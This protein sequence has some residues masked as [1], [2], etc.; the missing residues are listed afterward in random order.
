VAADVAYNS[1]TITL[2]RPLRDTAGT[3]TLLVG[4]AVTWSVICVKF[5]NWNI[6]A[7]DQV[8]W[9]GPFVFAESL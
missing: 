7:R 3:Y 2:H 9:D 5:P 8:A 4:Q 1:N 6:F